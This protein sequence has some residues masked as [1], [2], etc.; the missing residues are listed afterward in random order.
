M[1]I[2]KKKN[3]TPFFKFLKDKNPENDYQLMLK[4]SDFSASFGIPLINLYT[5][6]LEENNNEELAKNL[7]NIKSFYKVGIK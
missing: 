1:D 5:W 4:I 2:Y 6:Y 3:H 7:A